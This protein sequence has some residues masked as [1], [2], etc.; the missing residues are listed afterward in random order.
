MIIKTALSGDLHVNLPK[1]K[2]EA[3][4]IAWWMLED[5]RVKGVH[6][7][8][9]AGDIVDGPLTEAD[10][11]WLIDFGMGCSDVA[12]TIWIDG[13]HEI[14]LALR[15]AMRGRQ[16][17][18]PIII[19]DGAG[20]HVVETPAGPLAVACVSFPKRAQLLA[21]I[22]P[23]DSEAV[24]AVAGQ[25]LQDVFRG[26]GVRVHDLALPT[27]ALI[28]GTVQ[29]SKVADDDQPDRPLGMDIPLSDLDLLGA[30]FYNV[31]HI[32]KPQ[33]W[34]LPSGF[35]VATP[36]CPFYSDYGE[37]KHDKGYILLEIESFEKPTSVTDPA[38]WMGNWTPRV[39]WSRV[40]TPATPMILCE[41]EFVELNGYR[42]LSIIRDELGEHPD[43]KIGG[44]PGVG[45]GLKGADIRF[46][47]RFQKDQRDSARK[48]AEEW[49]RLAREL[50][51]ATNVT[52]DPLLIPT[53]RARIP[54][55]ATTPLLKDKWELYVASIGLDLTDERRRTLLLMLSTLQ[56][57]AAAAG[58]DIVGQSRTAPRLRG[59][60]RLRGFLKFPDEVTIDFDQ[61][62]GN[63]TAI[64]APNEMGKTVLMQLLGPGAQ[65][66]TTPDRGS[67]D[68]LSIAKDSFVQV[69]YALGR[70]EFTV[71]QNASGRDRKGS[72]SLIRHT[73]T[74][75]VPL[76][77]KAGRDEYKAW[78]AQHLLP[79]SVYNALVCQSG[80]ENIIDMDDGPRVEVLLRILGLEQYEVLAKMAR[81][82]AGN[83]DSELKQVQARLAE[84][85]P[86]DID[87]KSH[88]V[89]QL[90]NEV[91][92]LS[93]ASETADAT[94]AKARTAAV[95]TARI[96]SHFDSLV[97]RRSGFE[98]Q[99]GELEEQSKTLRA[100]IGVQEALLSQADAIA[101]AEQVAESLRTQLASEE[102]ARVEGLMRH[103]TV[104]A[105]HGNLVARLEEATNRQNNVKTQISNLENRIEEN[106]SSVGSYRLLLA[107]AEQ[108]RAAV[109]SVDELNKSLTEKQARDTILREQLIRLQGQISEAGA[110]LS[111][112]NQQQGSLQRRI[113]GANETLRD[114]DK[115]EQ[116]LARQK[117]VE[118]DHKNKESLRD[119]LRRQIDATQET[120]NQA[121][122]VRILH[123]RTGLEFIAERQTVQPS[124]H[125]ANVLSEDDR[126]VTSTVEQGN[127]VKDLVTKWQTCDAEVRQLESEHRMLL[128]DTSKAS[129]MEAARTALAEAKETLA[130][131][132]STA[133]NISVER[134]GLVEREEALTA[135]IK[136]VSSEIRV[137]R[138]QIDTNTPLAA[139]S[140]ELA[141]AE[142]QIATLEEQRS[143]LLNELLTHRQDLQVL[144]INIG[145]LGGDV[146]AKADELEDI[147][148]ARLKVVTRIEGM[149]AKLYE[150]APMLAQ[151][152]ALN[153]ARVHL[154]HL[155]TKLGDVVLQSEEVIGSLESVNNEIAAITI[156]EEVNVAELEDQVREVHRQYADCVA[157]LH[158]ARK[159][160]ENEE[161]R[162]ERQ[163]ELNR[164]CE[165][166]ETLSANW[167]LLA[168]HLGK[169]GLQKAEI[170]CAGPQLTDRT[171]EL[172]RAVGDLRHTVSI[173]TERLHSN[174]KGMVPCLNIN[175]F[176]SVEGITKESRLLSG[177]GKEIVGKP[178]SFALVGLACQRIGLSSFTLF[179]DEATGVMDSVNSSRYVGMLRNFAEMF[180]AHIIFVSQNPAIWDLADNLIKI[181][182]GIVT[183]VQQA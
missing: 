139:R 5:W 183:T 84:L 114:A 173:E 11:S 120:I 88:Q 165:Y 83:I 157:N 109:Q 23:A 27:V 82:E 155:S 6:F 180:N 35:T 59:K 20:V 34:T 85:G 67:L 137:L 79:K 63:L 143:A 68:D 151:R 38:A 80:S 57:Q 1:R 148:A 78:A 77:E 49:A 153:E 37:A 66:G 140:T 61:L 70:N 65:Y 147:G 24:D 150:L 117:K 36:S 112:N 96:R 104:S 131:L 97:A 135:D 126:S 47:Y 125:A 161:K 42:G 129:V 118:R 26:L 116:S 89:S 55:L 102:Q 113:N 162:A 108:I 91:A 181:D 25:A 167:K 90:H 76:L 32:H 106:V 44:V 52:L 33:H 62:Q 94:L 149:Q 127:L 111:G 123:L 145:V 3:Q 119:D 122:G 9:L 95:E 138:D 92:R 105:E 142:S 50:G 10:R 156:P 51:G 74:G 19:E 100:E 15:N 178:F 45:G 30:H 22:G 93:D 40:P 86:I 172:L 81:D 46:R 99:R 7:I 69:A 166:L 160:L 41:A 174:K 152:P 21:N 154:Q 115:V 107:D 31:A 75:E 141:V 164:Q 12:P 170:N 98:Q 163:I 2:E 43:G 175:V 60:A 132:V 8:G 53:V 168:D 73:S 87:G 158:G 177:A 48:D 4:R 103:N 176:D 159:D 110:W 28:H 133:S 16:G 72:V 17:K 136:T 101:Q 14:G 144:E 13:N 18:Y 124:E 54:E 29:G 58:V 171:N 71:T 169:D 121:S 182:N 39:T 128:K 56:D 134:K 130:E 146:K 64:V 179:I